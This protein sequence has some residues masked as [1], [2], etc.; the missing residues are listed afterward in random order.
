MILTQVQVLAAA[1]P[2]QETFIRR[3]LLIFVAA[4]LHL[5]AVLVAMLTVQTVPMS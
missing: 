4:V 1:S 3:F 2:V 5:E